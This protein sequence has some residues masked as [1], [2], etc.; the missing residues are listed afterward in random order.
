MISAILIFSLTVQAGFA[1]ADTAVS[2]SD[3][4]GH[5]AE[6]TLQSWLS[7][8]YIQADANGMVKPDE[9][10][11][12]MEW[13]R[14]INAVFGFTEEAE[15]GFTDPG[16]SEEMRHQAA[17]AVRAGYLQGYED[18][19]F[20]PSALINRAEAAVTAAK[21]SNL[22]LSPENK[23]WHAF[24][25][26]NKIADWARTSIAAVAANRIMS[27]YPD[28]SFRPRGQ[29]TRA[30]AAVV[31][32]RTHQ[33]A[34]GDRI[35]DQAG[36]YGPD[37][38]YEVIQGN[39]I[40]Q[41][42]GVTLRNM[43]IRGDLLLG[44][45][46]GSGEATLDGVTVQGTTTVSGGGENSIHFVNAVLATVIV[47]KQ[48]GIVRI[49]AEG[50]TSCEEV[51][52]R[53]SA[54]VNNADDL[55]QGGFSH[56]RLAEQLTEEA[57]ITLIGS[58]NEVTV[59]SDNS[60]LKLY[61]GAVIAKLT[62]DDQAGSGLI[63]MDDKAKITH[64]VLNAIAKIIGGGIIETAT[65]NEQAKQSE[66]DRRP[67]AV[68]GSQKDSIR[69]VGVANA[70]GSAGSDSGSGSGSETPGSGSEDP[71]SGSEDPD[72][73]TEDPELVNLLS[74]P[75]FEEG[76]I[77]WDL[78]DSG[79][80]VTDES[81]NVHSGSHAGRLPG[82]D[83][84]HYMSQTLS[85]NLQEDTEYELQAYGKRG[86]GELG[87]SMINVELKDLNGNFL[88]GYVGGNNNDQYAAMQSWVGEAD[89]AG[90]TFRSEKFTAPAGTVSIKVSAYVAG[91]ADFYVDDIALIGP[92]ADSEETPTEGQEGEFN[93]E[94][95]HYYVSATEG[96]DHNPGTLAAP[97]RTIQ[98]AADIALS[99]DTVYIRG[100]TYDETVIPAGSGNSSQPIVYA[101]Y[102]GEDIRLSGSE[103]IT[104]AWELY[105]GNIYKTKT[106]L[107]LGTKNAVF[108]DKELMT[109]AR[110]PNSGGWL[111][112]SPALVDNP[113]STP[114]QLRAETSDGA[115][116]P[117]MDYAGAKVWIYSNWIGWTSPILSSA[118]G[119][120]TINDNAPD[121]WTQLGYQ[122]NPSLVRY[123]IYDG[124]K[125]LDAE[126]EWYYD[127]TAGELYL[128]APDGADPNDLMIEKKTREVA[129][130]LNNRSWL[131]FD[132]ITIQ[133]ATI[134]GANMNHVKLNGLQ[135]KDYGYDSDSEGKYGSQLNIGLILQ[136]DGIE[137]RNTEISNS[138]GYGINIKGDN[139]V[140]FNNYIHDIGYSGA[141]TTGIEIA[142]HDAYIGYN[143]ISYTGGGCINGNMVFSSLIEYNDFGFCGAIS[144]DNGTMHWAKNDYQNTEVRYNYMHDGLDGASYI[145]LDNGS[146]NMI[147]HH[148]TV[149]NS[150]IGGKNAISFN[151]PS[152]Y[153]LFYNNVVDGGIS[154]VYGPAFTD[155]TYKLSVYDNVFTGKIEITGP[156][157]VRDNASTGFAKITEGGIPGHNF[158]DRPAEPSPLLAFSN[159]PK[160]NLVKNAGFEGML[161]KY[162][163][164]ND[165][166][167]WTKTGAMNAAGQLASGETI[168]QD[169]GF[170]RVGQ[171]S[172][173]LNGT[174][175]DGIE[176]TIQGLQS[177]KWYEFAAW[178]KVDAGEQAIVGVKGYDGDED[179]FRVITDT[180]QGW[181]QTILFFRTSDSA[182]SATIYLTK[183]SAGAGYVYGDD[184]GLV[185]V[186]DELPPP[187]PPEP[188]D[189]VLQNGD[190]EAGAEF[191]TDL[192][193]T[194]LLK[195]GLNISSG[196]QTM[197][198]G[199]GP[200]GGGKQL[201]T[202]GV[203]ENTDYIVSAWGRVGAADTEGNLQVRAL[204]ED[205][206]VI[207]SVPVAELIWSET[208]FTRK[209][210]KFT[211]PAGT[212]SFEVAFAK[213]SGEAAYDLDD[214][215][216]RESFNL[217]MN[218][219][220]EES[221]QAL[222]FLAA[223][224]FKLVTEPKAD[225]YEGVRSVRI[226]NEAPTKYGYAHTFVV[227]GV[228][229][230]TEYTF[231][232]WGKR[233][234]G[235]TTSGAFVSASQQFYKDIMIPECDG[236]GAAEAD[237]CQIAG[238]LQ[239]SETDWTQK[240]VTFTTKP[241]THVLKLVFWLPE[242]EAPLYVDNLSV[243]ETAN[244]L[245]V[246]EV[247]KSALNSV[248]LAAQ[249][250]M[251][252]A[253]VGTEAG[254]YPQSA[255]DELTAAIGAA[256]AVNLDPNAGQS[257]V[258]DAKVALQT[259]V[260]AFE[261]AKVP[262]SLP[263]GNLL[264]N[265]GFED[266]MNNWIIGGDIGAEAT[267]VAE[268]VYSGSQAGRLIGDADAHYLQQIIP[269]SIVEETDF[270]LS[271]WGK[272]GAAGDLG[273]AMVN[274]R[275]LDA[276]DN[277]LTPDN[278][279]AAM[280]TW[281]GESDREGYTLQSLPFTAPA[282]TAKLKLEIYVGGDGTNPYADFYLD[283]LSVEQSS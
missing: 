90:F 136:G 170:T 41:H 74:D 268:D 4:S 36:V 237:Q 187:P 128:Y 54:I 203:K 160:R 281:N 102:Q 3:I 199:S 167:D 251:D 182:T 34:S 218:P 282:G 82:G 259:A 234:T 208:A 188:G 265:P 248:I 95:T 68:D 262:E 15:A 166:R 161:D 46:I 7:E 93:P 25:D 6:K 277:N 69:I 186:G 117:N 222:Y 21:V 30:E 180:E 210:V 35:I 196:V 26:G 67:G 267:A 243:V 24:A 85:V 13:V 261:A 241:G 253:E 258:N 179:Q 143:T 108:V 270:T 205:G 137:I 48:N 213:T 151:Q 183:V 45:E 266:G 239:W 144:H 227:H 280:L 16:L 226:T 8:G 2:K 38:G 32:D 147:I 127:K 278:G 276:D 269:A 191:W 118:D 73:G 63:D 22:E 233:G 20:R 72:S 12:R 164:A 207:G 77:G 132:G 177:D 255:L 75:G 135:I 142:G 219:G 146:S 96:D 112:R 130:N 154:S 14:M 275:L 116:L 189:N 56:I 223:T 65:I 245:V 28:G 240:S 273:W 162:F 29:L 103:R 216:L 271:A 206:A 19:S 229:E 113:H 42:E 242:G 60:V 91:E 193:N 232:V 192:N 119:V 221:D 49:V 98:K 140:L 217:V 79:F 209:S 92:A 214:L 126:N 33:V 274:I 44:E 104:S 97:F 66:F 131:E 52:L 71:G 31:L 37:S 129:L 190:F 172:V 246:E 23:A 252:A 155:D 220:F 47:D 70:S 200:S 138:S 87:W 257:Q 53:S 153:V 81:S 212:A 225:V 171:G 228:S 169:K 272:R 204:D 198:V 211:T 62:V 283:D 9:A 279:Y 201:V 134:A 249:A 168:G 184:F 51:V 18:G 11:T 263:S 185:F 163:V 55:S 256:Q 250:A 106:M 40:V 125:L 238:L 165:L 58:F 195:P 107:E 120:L 139:A 78:G 235:G 215:A 264:A 230:N 5:W 158:I 61:A 141:F 111:E 76:A 178:T 109:P 10:I 124:L 1:S 114:T 121:E 224:N 133:G 254:Q 43:I 244:S 145:Y 83:A 236:L 100:G 123:Y 181:V 86:P 150:T 149:F 247:D 64:L 156:A 175:P 194:S 176:Q 231:S 39:V 159:P 173:R 99:G 202:A 105:S 88:A 174:E 152:N 197:R 80:T 157:E 17:V 260:A 89:Q 84:A 27:G 94:P 122:A 148:N 110:W 101:A 115:Q 59:E 57:S 50:A